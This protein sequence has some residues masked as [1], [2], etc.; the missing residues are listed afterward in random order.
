MF[1]RSFTSTLGGASVLILLVS[2]LTKGVGFV[3]EIIYANNFGLGKEFD[4]FLVS[5]AL[6]IILYTTI[7][8]LGQ[9]YFVPAYNK[10]KKDNPSYAN[11]FFFENLWMFFITGVV[12]ALLLFLSTDIIIDHYM[13]VSSESSRRIASTIFKI[14]TLTVPLSAAFSI[15]AGFFN[16]EYKFHYPAFS[17][18]LL[19]VIVV[20]ILIIFSGYLH[21][22]AI[23]LA[24]ISGMFLQDIYLVYLAR[25]YFKFNFSN[26]LS[27]KYF[28]G[29]M[30]KNLV[31]ILFADIINLSYVLVDRYFYH[32]VDPGGIASLQYALTLFAL[33]ITTI[34]YALATTLFSKFSE[35]FNKFN[36][37]EIEE[38]FEKAL[39]FIVFLFIPIMIVYII[40]GDEIIRVFFQRGA[41]K[42]EDTEL[43]FDVLQI[44]SLSLVF[45]AGYSIVNKLLYGTHMLKQLLLVSIVAFVLKVILNFILVDSLKQFGLA[46]ATSACYF[47][48][49]SAG[50]I[51]VSIHNKFSNKNFIIKTLLLYFMN[52][53][54]SLAIAV[55]ILSMFDGLG[56]WEDVLMLVIFAAIFVVN[57]YYLK[58]AEVDLLKNLLKSLT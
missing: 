15:L 9:N 38:H 47:F 12:I 19:N 39:K 55:L 29:L 20:I 23:P 13:K 3:R 40:G 54:I 2:I 58:T 5:A 11:Y 56:F 17:K 22:Y 21:I 41:F 4:I 34:S 37:K 50:F 6:P 14:L 51:F 45:Y 7:I 30:N 48:L 46:Y 33:P 10:I 18:L 1:K 57:S 49:F 44:Y 16:A 26:L 36:R 8:Y 43:T 28:F 42:Q 35:S 25:K 52:A 24:I 32:K 31:F 53:L 27:I